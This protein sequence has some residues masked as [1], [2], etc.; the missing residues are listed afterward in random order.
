MR[1]RPPGRARD[2]PDLAA[3]RVP[4][5][6]GRTRGDRAALAA[7]PRRRHLRRRRVRRHRAVH[8]SRSRARRSE[9]RRSRRAFHEIN[10]R[11]Y[12]HR[13]G[14]DPGV[15][16]FSLDAPAVWPSRAR[17]SGTGCRTSTPTS[18][19]DERDG[20][21]IDYRSH[22]RRSAARLHRA[23]PARR[24]RWRPPPPARSSSSWPSA[25]CC[26]RRPGAGC[27][28]PA[29]TTRR[30]RC[31]RRS[32]RRRADA[33]H[34]RRAAAGRLRGAAS[35]GPLRARGRRRDPRPR[36]HPIAPPP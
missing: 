17:A 22:R 11:T 25:T 20:A 1:E 15:W 34:R 26:I 35:A 23:L 30:T 13:G 6:A 21:G 27:A 8:D 4:A 16:F 7:R 24:G 9:R 29:S 33:D 10:L 2:A 19:L 32:R 28:P 14:R 31:S 36:A 5:L 18:T 3:P 12:V